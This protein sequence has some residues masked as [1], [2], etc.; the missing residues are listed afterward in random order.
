MIQL[1][2]GLSPPLARRSDPDTSHDA[3]RRIEPA[4]SS[5][6]MRVVGALLDQILHHPLPGDHDCPQ[7]GLTVPE[8]S[9][10]TGI[11]K[12][13]ISPRMKPLER[14]GCVRRLSERRNGATIWVV[15]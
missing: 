5:L 6:E 11:D 8:I 3:A 9:A 4:V 13:S 2:L 1:G 10:H 14:K 7:S 12:W 15:C